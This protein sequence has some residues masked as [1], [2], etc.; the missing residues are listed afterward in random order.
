[1]T[2]VWTYKGVDIFPAG[3]VVFDGLRWYARLHSGPGPAMLRA[4][5]KDGMRE[6]ITHY[7]G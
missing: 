1:V 4:T 3:P 5:S 7:L 6:M 2:G